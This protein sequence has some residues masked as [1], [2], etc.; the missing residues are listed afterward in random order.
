MK[1]NFQDTLRTKTEIKNLTQNK[2]NILESIRLE[3]A[4]RLAK[5]KS[6][7]GEISESKKIYEDILSRFPKNRK[8]QHY[9][10]NLFKKLKQSTVNHL[11]NLYNQGQF[12]E[13]T[14]SS[15]KMLQLSYHY[16]N[17]MFVSPKV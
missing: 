10:V 2:P 1:E 13:R 6:K 16:Q 3:Q 17:Q 15:L 8:A 7:K 11:I 12:L 14:H 9:L 5:K 4:L